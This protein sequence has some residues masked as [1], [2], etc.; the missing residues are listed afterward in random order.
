MSEVREETI[1][2]VTFDG[3][4]SS[5]PA[6]EEKFLARAKRRGYKDLLLRRVDLGP[7]NAEVPADVP[8]EKRAEVLRLRDLNEIAYADLILAVDTTKPTG[9]VVFNMIKGTKTPS[10]LDWN[11]QEAWASLKRKFQPNTAPTK[12]KLHNVFYKTTMKKG[13]DPMNFI[14][15]LE[16]IRPKLADAGD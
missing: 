3:K 16:D 13:A 2:V 12:S 10:Y 11:A 15:Y 5:W 4:K 14:T 8:A 6:W 7:T 9:R 1:K